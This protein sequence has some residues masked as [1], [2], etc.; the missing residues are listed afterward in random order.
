[1]NYT[2]APIT[3]I[4]ML[5]CYTS[6]KPE[7]EVGGPSV[8]NS[9]AGRETRN[10]LRDNGLVGEDWRATEKGIA[11]VQFICETPLPVSKWVLPEERQRND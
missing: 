2:L 1:M 3:I 7:E 5:A 10:W 6:P 9:E 4:Y 11:W 8:W